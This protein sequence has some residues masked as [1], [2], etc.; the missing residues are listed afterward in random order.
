MMNQYEIM[1]EIL[2]GGGGG[3][4]KISYGKVKGSF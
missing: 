2:R 3:Y 4:P 1:A